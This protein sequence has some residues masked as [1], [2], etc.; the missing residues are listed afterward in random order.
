MLRRSPLPL[1][2]DLVPCPI[3]LPRPPRPLPLY[4]LY[5]PRTPAPV[6]KDSS[7]CGGTV[8]VLSAVFVVAL[9]SMLVYAK[10]EER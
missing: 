8:A 10:I 6:D 5:P 7:T 2:E 9:F 3:R 1:L 4:P